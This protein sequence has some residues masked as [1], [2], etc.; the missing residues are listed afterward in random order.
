MEEMR[1][2]RRT[3]L[4]YAVA[5]FT[6]AVGVT[7]YI[8]SKHLSIDEAI[9]ISLNKLKI[10]LNSVEKEAP[11]VVEKN[12]DLW[13]EKKLDEN[14]DKFLDWYYSI[15]GE[16]A[17]LIYAAL[18]KGVDIFENEYLR[19]KYTEFQNRFTETLFNGILGNTP[20]E[21]K[22]LYA[23]KL[24]IYKK[25]TL[26]IFS[27]VEKIDL[28]VL[29]EILNKLEKNT[30]LRVGITLSVSLKFFSFLTRRLVSRLSRIFIRKVG[31]RI[32]LRFGMA[33]F[34]SIIGLACANFAIACIG[35]LNV[36]FDILFRRL[37]AFLNRD[38]LKKEIRMLILNNLQQIKDS[39]KEAVVAKVE[40]VNEEIYKI[41][42]KE[43]KKLSPY[44]ILKD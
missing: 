5:L 10:L 11:K 43:F 34:L 35:A 26:E 22:N 42:K 28:N 9:K 32:A 19:E 4:K 21:I 12:I 18:E 3:L 27:N 40:N 1:L 38:E 15:G 20:E 36:A 2:S 39:A 31:R 30:L 41:A 23:Q 14:I 29:Q 13:V 8:N 24:D 44:E 16:I 6:G 7:L 25:E 33:R 37:D 17:I